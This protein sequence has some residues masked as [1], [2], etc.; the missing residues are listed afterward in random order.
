MADKY[1]LLEGARADIEEQAN[2]MM[3]ADS[4][5]I[6]VGSAFFVAL[7]D[8]YAQTMLRMPSDPARYKRAVARTRGSLLD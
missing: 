2:A 6:P 7:P 5:W 1:K 8:T 4:N 3:E